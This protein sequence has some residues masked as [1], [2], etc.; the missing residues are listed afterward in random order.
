[1]SPEWIPLLFAAGV[2]VLLHFCSAAA[3]DNRSA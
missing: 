3:R 2:I 1:M